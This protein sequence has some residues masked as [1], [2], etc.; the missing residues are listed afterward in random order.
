VSSARVAGGW[1]PLISEPPLTAP[2]ASRDDDEAAAA[3]E[4]MQ[5]ATEKLRAR[6]PMMKGNA[7]PPQPSEPA[8]T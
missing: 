8:G 6:L 3:A 4:Q 7:V 2:D 1:T 5:A